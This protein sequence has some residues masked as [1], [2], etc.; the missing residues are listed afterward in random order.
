MTT[1]NARD[2]QH[3]HLRRSCPECYLLAIAKGFVG[4]DATPE[5][6]ME[7]MHA[8]IVRQERDI[9]RLKAQHEFDTRAKDELR[10]TVAKLLA[11][12]P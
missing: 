11:Q 9:E 8:R 7:A 6:A 5:E 2:C 1:E 10:L 4:W 12:K 3:G